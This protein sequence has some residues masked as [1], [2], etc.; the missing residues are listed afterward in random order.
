ML[1]LGWILHLFIGS[2][3]AGIGVIAALVL[4]FDTLN[5]VLISAALGFLAAV[6]VT[7]MVTRALIERG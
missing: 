1:R 2:T 7:W 3:L 4:G 6:P 5:P